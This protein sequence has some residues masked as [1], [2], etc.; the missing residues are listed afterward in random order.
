MKENSL[1]EKPF[2]SWKEISAYL[3]CD[4]RTCLRWEKKHGLPVHRA[5]TKL[6][7]SLVFAYK[8]ELDEW[9]KR[10][11]TGDA[12]PE[13]PMGVKRSLLGIRGP[14]W[15]AV[16][17][18]VIIG[19]LLLTVFAGKSGKGGMG[20][21]Q[22][23]AFKI[24]RSELIVLDN[25]GAVLWRYD[26]LLPDLLD[27][28]SYQTHFP[29]RKG[30]GDNER[31]LPWVKIEDIDSDGRTEVLFTIHTYNE[32]AELGLYCFDHRG[33]ILWTYEPGREMT[34]GTR[35]FSGDYALDAVEVISTNPAGQKKI[36]IL[37]RHIPNFPS[38]LA[39]LSPEGKTLGEY[40]NAGRFSDYALI[41]ID[42]D[43][44]PALHVSGTNNEYGRGFLATLDID[45]VWGCSPQTAEFQAAGLKPGAELF[46]ILFPR[47][48][49][50]QLEFAPR[51][52][53]GFVDKLKNKGIYAIPTSSRIIFEFNRAMEIDSVSLSD[54]FR[55]KYRKYQEEGRVPPGRLDEQ[56][57][58]DTLAKGVMYY[59]GE[60][61]SMKRTFN[62]KNRW[63]F[64]EIERRK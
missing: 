31:K 37:A 11:E 18:V 29:C 15:L 59:D 57:L 9:L 12:P 64:V 25:Q 27:N 48:V 10:H 17:P 39:I 26:T 8:E 63:I 23:Y 7:K 52:V 61:W 56:F 34:F 13:K 51:E 4:E 30:I 54:T 60:Q 47:T 1:K 6:S 22:P 32:T 14:I 42:D 21:P 33:R 58:I 46:Y 3:G 62:N 45:H 49:V 2:S 24:E 38:Y 28:D 53:L 44:Y 40:W 16:I 20:S 55:E 35:H 41:D 19:V 50:D 43:G 5:G 36:L